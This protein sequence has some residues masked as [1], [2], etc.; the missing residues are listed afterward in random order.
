M[1]LIMHALRSMEIYRFPLPDGF[2]IHQPEKALI[3]FG[4]FGS[5]DMGA[6]C[7]IKR[8][9]R[10]KSQKVREVEM[11]TFCKLRM[12]E[13][14]NLLVHIGILIDRSGIGLNTLLTRCSLFINFI[15]WCDS[16]S[17]NHVLSDEYHARAAY[18]GYVEH[19]RML[20][21]QNKIS[22]NSG[23]NYQGAAR[24]LTESFLN[25]ENIGRGTNQ[26]HPCLQEQKLTSVP[27]DESQQR[28][29]AW[30]HCLFHGFSSLIL[31]KKPYPFA[32]RVPSYLNW[33]SNQLWI[34]PSRQRWCKSPDHKHSEKRLYSLEFDYDAGIAYSREE[35]EERFG[36]PHR[37]RHKTM[38]PTEKITIANADFYCNSRIERGMLACD[39]F[40]LLFIAT[41][42][43]NVAQVINLPWNIE[44]ESCVS[45]PVV[46]R[47]N[48]RAIK[49]RANNRSVFFEVGVEFMQHLRCYLQLRKFLLHD[50]TC[51]FLFFCYG[52]NTRNI[53]F[54]PVQLSNRSTL[55][56]FFQTLRFLSP[57]IPIITARQWRA[58]KQD[59]VIR[60]H[61]PITAAKVMQHSIRTSL[62]KYS[63]GSEVTQQ[64]ELNSFFT[65]VENVILKDKQTVP[66]SE[67][68]AVGICIAPKT[69]KALVQNF[70]IKP[71]CQT[72]EGCLNCDK[73]RVHADD[74]DVRKLLSAR[75]C[76]SKTSILATNQEEFDFLFK[77]TLQRIDFI[78]SEIRSTHTALVDT[79]E[80]QVNIDCDLDP[81]WSSKFEMLMELGVI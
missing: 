41:T 48:F 59:Y 14:S 33:K 40:L 5:L 50:K 62:E 47:Q 32:L 57:T 3:T 15:D 78:V 16:N 34:F 37:P 22:H 68:T 10:G 4:H 71:L 24:R 2:S 51:D 70:L 26:L 75:Y 65:N 49:Y 79:I 63:N 69:P 11:E 61:D 56:H 60:K 52:S 1:R 73:Y 44:L 53:N 64:V 66:G 21:S 35:A 17:H 9:P 43:M 39:A 36:K 31:D 80:H 25:I 55:K 74:K 76:I 54:N 45:D 81:Y 27:D 19:I 46:E 77:N 72:P 7:Y 58:A 29:L 20:V 67:N 13:I 38:S 23:V 6:L 8:S 30:C 28:I 42:G 12:K 18:R